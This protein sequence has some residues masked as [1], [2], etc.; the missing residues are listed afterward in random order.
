MVAWIYY[1]YILLLNPLL[2]LNEKENSGNPAKDVQ[3][4]FEVFYTSVNLMQTN[5]I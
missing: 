4:V 5:F 1:H 2:Q 3:H